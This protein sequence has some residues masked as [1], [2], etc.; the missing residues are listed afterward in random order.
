MAQKWIDNY[1]AT[2]V[3][4]CCGIGPAHIQAT[5]DWKNKSIGVTKANHTSTCASDVSE[6]RK[7]TGAQRKELSCGVKGCGCGVQI[8]FGQKIPFLCGNATAADAKSASR[9]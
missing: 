5:S 2:V 4:G 1:G 3:G 7:I 9:P 8:G 6:L